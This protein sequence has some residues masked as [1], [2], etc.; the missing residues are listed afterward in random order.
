MD[1]WGGGG[2]KWYVGPPL[3]FLEDWP[4][5]PPLSTPML[6]TLYIKTVDV[7][8]H[9]SQHVTCYMVFWQYQPNLAL[10]NNVPVLQLSIAMLLTKQTIA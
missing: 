7:L 3:K 4:P 6:L 1:Y 9:S 2:G 10:L 5:L 8:T